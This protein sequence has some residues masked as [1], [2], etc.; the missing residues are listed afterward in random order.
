MATKAN[1]TS[2][3]A[4]RDAE[5]RKAGWELPEM[6]GEQWEAKIA[7]QIASM[8]KVFG[9]NHD[10][11][12]D[13]MKEIIRNHIITMNREYINMGTAHREQYTD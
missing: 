5:L 4:S 13:N 7:E 12:R 8:M 11:I 1:C 2:S 6:T 10:A 3:I 9:W